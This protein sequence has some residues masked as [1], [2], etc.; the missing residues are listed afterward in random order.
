[1]PVAWALRKGKGGP[2]KKIATGGFFC[3]NQACEYYGISDE[4]IH[5]LVEYETHGKQESI[6]DLSVR[7][8]E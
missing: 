1:M 3:A 8:V 4:E 6:Q 7:R 2:K 5:A